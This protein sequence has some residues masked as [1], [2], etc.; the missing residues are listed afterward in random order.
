M[1]VLVRHLTNQILRQ[2]AEHTGNSGGEGKRERGVGQGRERERERRGER[3]GGRG[4][5]RE[6]KVEKLNIKLHV[7]GNSLTG[8]PWVNVCEPPI[9]AHSRHK[10]ILIGLHAELR[11]RPISKLL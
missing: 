6:R 9:D 7:R 3:E 10:L 1:I 11:P 8:I 5:G 4:G 2:I